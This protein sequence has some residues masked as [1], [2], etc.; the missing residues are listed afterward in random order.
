MTPDLQRLYGALLAHR[1][2]LRAT[3]VPSH[4]EVLTAFGVSLEDDD[5]PSHW[6][7]GWLLWEDRVVELWERLGGDAVPYF[8]TMWDSPDDFCNSAR[9]QALSYIL[10]PSRD[11]ADPLAVY[12]AGLSDAV[13]T[14]PAAIVP[15]AWVLRNRDALW[16]VWLSLNRSGGDVRQ[17]IRD[18]RKGVVDE[19]LREYASAGCDLDV[20]ELDARCEMLVDVGGDQADRLELGEA[21]A[22][23]RALHGAHMT[24]RGVGVPEQY[25]RWEAGHWHPK[26]ANGAL[27]LGDYDVT[28]VAAEWA[29][30]LDA[31]VPHALAYQLVGMQPVDEAMEALATFR[32]LNAEGGFPFALVAAGLDVPDDTLTDDE[33]NTWCAQ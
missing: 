10:S 24:L 9:E 18:V 25:A 31:G 20:D 21:L 5:D 7:R 27:V 22:L 23:E 11:D 13:N 26:D 4:D 2:H 19:L 1:E 12:L 16:E 3:F 28:E 32:E 17:G 33:W 14:C 29:R 15:L 8:R 6:E 30:Y